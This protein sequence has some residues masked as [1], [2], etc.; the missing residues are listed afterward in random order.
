MNIKQT[1]ETI[2]SQALHAAGAV[3]SP[4]IV[5]Q[6]QKAEFGHYQANGVMGAAKKVGKNPRELATQVLAVL[7]LPQAEKVEIAG[8]GFINIHLSE[9]YVADC[10]TALRDD[11]RL[12]IQRVPE[13]K[14]VIDYSAPNLAKEMHIGHLRST[15]IGDAAARIL[16]FLGH[17]VIRA[18]HVGD[19]G[20]QF[21]SLLAYMDQ[22]EQAGET[23]ATELKDLEVFYRNASA[24]FKTD[25]EFAKRARKYVVLLQ[26]G[27]PKCLERRGNCGDRRWPRRFSQYPVWVWR[28]AWV[29]K[30]NRHGQSRH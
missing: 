8:P 25:E 4:A 1:L 20:A 2:I 3:D 15:T 5:K 21:G 14:I 18:N 11:N 29:A 7:D 26:G 13:K 19:W 23:L 10:L 30:T 12:G 9:Q 24:L 27:D 16:E 28:C 17:N 22:L 6:S